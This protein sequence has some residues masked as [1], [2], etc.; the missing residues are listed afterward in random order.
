MA[1]LREIGLRKAAKFGI[2]TLALLP[3]RWLL[4]PQLRAIYL[5]LLGARVA[6]EAIIHDVTFFNAYRTGFA[7]LQIGRRCF[8]ANNACWIW[9]TGSSCTSMSHWP[10]A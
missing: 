4:V 5:R 9:P 6:P 2:T 10:N 8:W 7:G 3:W 1:A